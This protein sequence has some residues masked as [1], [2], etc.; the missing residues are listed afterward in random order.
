MKTVAVFA[1]LVVV[2]SVMY[3]PTDGASQPRCGYCN[4]MECPQ[5]NC[6]CGAYMD[7]CNCCALCR[8]CR[9]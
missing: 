8:N 2:L 7:A 3:S 4:P 1:L 9:G 6:P 5:V